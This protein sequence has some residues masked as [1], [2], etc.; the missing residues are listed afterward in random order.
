[1]KG[2]PAHHA[3]PVG[4]FVV[5][6]LV[7]FLA[8][9][10][11]ACALFAVPEGSCSSWTS[12]LFGVG[13]GGVLTLWAS[14]AFGERSSRDFAERLDQ[15][16]SEVIRRGSDA[17]VADVKRKLDEVKGELGREIPARTMSALEAQTLTTVLFASRPA[18]QK[19]LPSV[20][21]AILALIPEDEK[22][23]IVDEAQRRGDA[24]TDEAG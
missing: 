12:G 10:D 18:I 11:E 7:W 15:A 23:R 2:L 20:V 4:V 22:K 14:W 5:L 19:V 9:S 13:I 17:F 24:G 1:M 3:V 16:V 6:L 8:P 21:D